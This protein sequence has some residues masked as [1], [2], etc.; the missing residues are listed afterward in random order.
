MYPT[1]RNLHLIFGLLSLPFLIMYAVSAVQMAHGRLFRIVP[2]V[3]ERRVSMQ[4]GYE[5]A[6]V[7]ARDLM[8][9]HGLKGEL[10]NVQS[11]PSGMTMRIVVPATVHDVSYDKATGTTNIKTSVSGVLGM[12]NRLHHAA[13]LW[14]EYRPLKLWGV[15]VGLVS[16]ALMGLGATGIYM[17]W[18]RKQERKAGIILI[19]SNIAY[20]LIL[21]WLIRSQGP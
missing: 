16:L 13:G 4:P 7:L 20:C 21:L 14:P 6:R 1:I 19:A 2:S 5:N 8:N 11:K 18:K 9:A 12:L 10:N 17:W 15:A 3:S